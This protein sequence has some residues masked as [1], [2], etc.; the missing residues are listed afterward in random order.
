MLNRIVQVCIGEES[1]EEVWRPA[2]VVR[3]WG[4]GCV[5]VQVF[6]DGTNDSDF[7]SVEECERG[8]RWEPS[9]SEGDSVGHWRWPP[10]EESA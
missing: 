2:I 9:R 10:R 8:L 1:G 5:N 7:A 6:L 4:G 3:D